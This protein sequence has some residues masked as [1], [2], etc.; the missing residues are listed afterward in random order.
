[1]PSFFVPSFLCNVFCAECNGFVNCYA[2]A[3]Q[4]EKLGICRVK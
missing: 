1:M 4:S 3:Y 2:K